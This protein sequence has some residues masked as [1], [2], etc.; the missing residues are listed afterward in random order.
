MADDTTIPSWQSIAPAS[1][2]PDECLANQCED[3][4]CVHCAG[5]GLG[6]DRLD[7]AYAASQGSLQSDENEEDD[8]HFDSDEKIG[9]F[10]ELDEPAILLTCKEIRQQCLPL[11]YA[12]NSFSW[13]FLWQENVRS[14]NRFTMWVTAIQDEQAALVRKISFESR[15]QYA[16]GI[17]FD[18]DIDLVKQSPF[19]TVSVSAGHPKD[20][21]VEVIMHE[22]E[23]ALVWCLWNMSKKGTVKIILS[24][25]RLVT[26]GA[27]F[28]R[29]MDR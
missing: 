9:M 2:V 7:E 14:M 4:K 6:S 26:L 12:L 19:F 15:H 23:R 16:E 24:T 21:E 20:S 1:G 5:H 18:A 11:Y 3:N 17:E 29:A 8:E 28:V 25:N 10:Y 22:L 13:R 27:T